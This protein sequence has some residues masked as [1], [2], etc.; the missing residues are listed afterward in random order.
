MVQNKLETY[1]SVGQASYYTTHTT[2][3]VRKPENQIRTVGGKNG[4]FSFLTIGV[5]GEVAIGE[6]KLP[7]LSSGSHKE[8][9]VKLSCRKWKLH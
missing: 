6:L 8:G 2:V 1:L 3:L 4:R 9:K 7:F 5:C